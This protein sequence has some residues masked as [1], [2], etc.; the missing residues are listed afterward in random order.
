MATLVII[1][2]LVGGV[3]G[4]AL[5]GVGGVIAVDADMLTR[6]I[7]RIVEFELEGYDHVVDGSRLC[8]QFM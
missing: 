1:A 5:G 7:S 6:V 8:M 2:V 3:F 4:L